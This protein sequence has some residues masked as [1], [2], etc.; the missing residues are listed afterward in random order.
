MT[1]LIGYTLGA[2]SGL[3]LLGSVGA[4][5]FQ[6]F[7]ETGSES[8]DG[9]ALMIKLLIITLSLAIFYYT[10]HTGFGKSRLEKVK[11]E[12]EIIKTRIEIEKVKNT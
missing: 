5:I 7:I 8:N 4:L 3:V 10:Y 9:E 11:E 6:L 12:L 2:I 1:R